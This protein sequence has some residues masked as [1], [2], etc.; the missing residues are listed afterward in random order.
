MEE[1]PVA[2]FTHARAQ[3]SRAM[4]PRVWFEGGGGLGGDAL[5]L[6]Q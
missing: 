2:I 6:H 3:A 5:G 1:S 4:H